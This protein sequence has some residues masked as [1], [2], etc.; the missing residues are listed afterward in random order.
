MNIKAN[1]DLLK[2]DRVK[3]LSVPASGGDESLSVG[4]CYAKAIS[5]NKKYLI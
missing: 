3:W 4:A 1:G 5:K 2:L